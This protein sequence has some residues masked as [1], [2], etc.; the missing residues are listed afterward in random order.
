MT[1]IAGPSGGALRDAT[2]N[3]P[4]SETGAPTPRSLADVAEHMAARFDDRLDIGRITRLVRQ[5]HRELVITTGVAPAAAVEIL[6]A[7]R[8]QRISDRG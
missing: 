1:T 2:V 7:R 3:R 6:A 8:L 4:R 5:C